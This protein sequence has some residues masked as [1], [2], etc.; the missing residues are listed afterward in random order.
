MVLI[1]I[2][3]VKRLLYLNYIGHVKASELKEERCSGK[4]L[5]AELP[6]GIKVLADLSRLESMDAE[7]TVEIGKM[8]EM[9]DEKGVEIVVRV[10]PDPSKD[11][12]FSILSMF[13]YKKRI[14]SV[15]CETL[16]EAGKAL[17]L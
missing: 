15:T 13:H 7:S 14:R 1:T 3:K 12:G 9:C 17:E 2:N 16:D 11:I 8:M 5:L 6:A 10:I 4:A